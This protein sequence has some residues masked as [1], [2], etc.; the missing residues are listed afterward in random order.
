VEHIPVNTVTLKLSYLNYKGKLNL[1]S[2]KTLPEYIAA[3]AQPIAML[4]QPMIIS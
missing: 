3:D 2:G 4:T 1:T